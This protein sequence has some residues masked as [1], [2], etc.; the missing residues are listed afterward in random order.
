MAVLLLFFLKATNL[1]F[2]LSLSAI[3]CVFHVS[4]KTEAEYFF[5][6]CDYAILPTSVVPIYYAFHAVIANELSILSFSIC[7]L[8]P[9]PS[10]FSHYFSCITIL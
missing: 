4:Q 9:I 5:D 3:N 1:S 7:R 10:C 8:D 6:P 2:P